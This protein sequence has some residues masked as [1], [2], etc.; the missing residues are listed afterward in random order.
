MK[1]KKTE[2]YSAAVI[3]GDCLKIGDKE[4]PI[5]MRNITDERGTMYRIDIDGDL[6][7]VSDNMHQATV[8]Y[9]LMRDHIVEYLTER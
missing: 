5:T 3:L 9:E 6:W 8:M 2:N 1:K 4:V 7:V